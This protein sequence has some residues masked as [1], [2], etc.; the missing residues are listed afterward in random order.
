MTFISG[1]AGIKEYEAEQEA[2]R[3]AASN[4]KKTEWLSLPK[5]GD[6]A[7]VVFAQELDEGSTNYSSQNGIGLFAIEHQA[8]PNWKV[9]ALCT[10]ND[11][12][13]YGCERHKAN[14]KEGWKGKVK[15]FINVLVENADGEWEVKVLSQGNGPSAITPTLIE[16]ATEVGTITNT[17]FKIKRTGEGKETKYILTPLGKEHGLDLESFE[18][19]DLQ[20][21]VR[22]VPYEQQEAFYTGGEVAPAAETRPAPLN[23]SSVD[24][25]W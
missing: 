13:C 10:A 24:A 19:F 16:L 25:D 11:G 21:C 5:D 15:L 2:R 18:L 7:K 3:E 22:K 14:Y 1:L 12:E 17:V 6:S 9:H 4:N 20:R 8:G 23:P